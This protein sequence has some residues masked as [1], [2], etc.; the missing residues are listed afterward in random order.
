MDAMSA[1]KQIDPLPVLLSRGDLI[2]PDELA[3]GM[4]VAQGTVYEW[5]RRGVIPFI[6]LEKCIR[7]DPEEIRE[8]LRA[9]HRA[10]RKAPGGGPVQAAT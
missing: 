4:K 5:V 1:K 10:A 6:Q 7:F 2:R 3:R 8:W 9:K